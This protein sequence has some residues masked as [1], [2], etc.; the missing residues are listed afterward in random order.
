MTMLI[1]QSI[2]YCIIS[3]LLIE[4]SDIRLM[5]IAKPHNDNTMESFCK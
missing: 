3:F 5:V 4:H 2:E 1:N